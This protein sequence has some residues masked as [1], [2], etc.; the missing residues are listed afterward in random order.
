MPTVKELIELAQCSKA[1]GVAPTPRKRTLTAR[2]IIKAKWRTEALKAAYLAGPPE[3]T[4]LFKCG[5]CGILYNQC[6]LELTT[7]SRVESR[8]DGAEWPCPACGSA[9]LLVLPGTK[10]HKGY[11][12]IPRSTSLQALCGLTEEEK[13]TNIHIVTAFVM[14]RNCDCLLEDLVDT[15][16]KPGTLAGAL[17]AAQRT[18]YVRYTDIVK[19]T[20]SGKEAYCMEAF[21]EMEGVHRDP[22]DEESDLM[23]KA[24]RLELLRFYNHKTSMELRE[25]RDRIAGRL[26]DLVLKTRRVE[27]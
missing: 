23:L 3:G 17:L 18:Y 25:A 22:T 27:Q 26:Q 12:T 13:E 7:S 9:C 5:S 2:E 11:Y 24:D 1:S 10:E 16:L 19:L 14:S 8:L 15:G 4:S 20:E 6:T 21:P